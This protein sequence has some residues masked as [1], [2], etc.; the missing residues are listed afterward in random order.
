M[1]YGV[2][3]EGEFDG[4]YGPKTES[5]VKTYQENN[6]LTVDGIVGKYTTNKLIAESNSPSYWMNKLILYM[7]FE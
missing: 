4:I 5:Q 3:N 6:D 2:E 7:A 1:N